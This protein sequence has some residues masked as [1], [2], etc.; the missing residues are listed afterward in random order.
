VKRDQIALELYT[1][2]SLTQQDFVGTLRAVAELGYPAVEFAGFGGLSAQELRGVLDGL[3]LR[4]MAAHVP[5]D[6]FAARLP[7][8]CADLRTLGIEYGVVPYLGEDRRG[9]VDQA[10]WLAETFNEW[11]DR[12]KD[13]GIRFG[14]H[15]HAFEFE[16]LPGEQPQT[17]FDILL[18]ETD[19]KVVMLELD[20]YWVRFA[21]ADPLQLIQAHPARFP[22][23][24]MKDMAAGDAKAIANVGEGVIDWP[25]IL[26]AAEAKTAW[27]VVEHDTPSDP[28]ADAER[29][30]RYLEGLAT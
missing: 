2:R 15:N 4:A 20:I 21:G 10:R 11:G 30:L 12:C 16:P 28:L 27:Y 6:E 8:V 7:Q 1:V 13:E 26:Q 18:T 19:P 22:I 3:G 23:L 17:M 9:D 24:H 14:Y 25:P 5:L 29:S